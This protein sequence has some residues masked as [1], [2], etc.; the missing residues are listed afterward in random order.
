MA[1]AELPG[2]RPDIALSLETAFILAHS[3]FVLI[4]IELMNYKKEKKNEPLTSA[5]G[6]G[7]LEG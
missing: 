4:F 1:E 6:G 7:R 5:E 2:P 3:E